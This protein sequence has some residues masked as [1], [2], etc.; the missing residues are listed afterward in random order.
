MNQK[1]FNYLKKYNKEVFLVNRLLV[2]TYVY[3]NNLKV[4]NNKKILKL[5]ICEQDG[6]ERVYD[7]S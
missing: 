4:N 7:F 5:I 3:L 2:S 6:D 1:I